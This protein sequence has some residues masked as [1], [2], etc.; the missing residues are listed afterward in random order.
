MSVRGSGYGMASSTTTPVD[1]ALDLKGL[2]ALVTGASK[3]IGAAIA[4]HLAAAG[5][6]LVVAARAPNDNTSIGHFIRADLST[7]EGPAELASATLQTLGGVDILVDNVAS[8]TRV[9][10]GVLAITDA[11]WLQDLS[12]TLLSAVRLDR[13]LLPD[14][15]AQRSGVIIHIGSNAARLPQPGALAYA[16]AKAALATYSKGLANQ[17]GVHNIRVNLISPE[18]SSPPVWRGVWK[19]SQTRTAPTS[20]VPGSNSPQ[21]STFH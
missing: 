1:N 3:G 7:P 2:R 13:A 19:S 8:Q 20:P 10:D 5:A 16:S 12:G 18:S 9:P 21:P 11:D 14:M 4:R 17:V 6:Q 15:I